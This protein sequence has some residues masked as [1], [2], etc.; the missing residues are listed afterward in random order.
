[1]LLGMRRT[2]PSSRLIATSLVAGLNAPL[3]AADAAQTIVI[4]ATGHA[5]RLADAPAAFSVIGAEQIA[6]RGTDEVYEALPPRTVGVAP[7]GRG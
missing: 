2:T 4:T 6:E 5:M 1:M 7:R 3:G